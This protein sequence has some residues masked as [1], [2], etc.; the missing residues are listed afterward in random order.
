M[1]KEDKK[2]IILNKVGSTNN[3]ASRL[4]LSDAAEEGTVVLTHFQT[5][6]RGQAGNYWESETGKNL[7]A[8]LILYPGFLN[9]AKQFAISKIVSLGLVDFLEREIE[10]VSI[11]WP[12][13]IYVENRKIAGILIENTV[14]GN[15]LAS[16]VVGIGLNLNQEKF[17]SDAPNP[18]SLKQI[19]GEIY[20]VEFVASE[21]LNAIFK[22]YEKLKLGSFSEIDTAYFSKLYGVGVWRKFIKN[23]KIFEAKIVGVG[24]FGQLWLEKCDGIIEEFMFKEVE[25]VV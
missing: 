9:A 20:D 16:L 21:I 1:T 18:V 4:I 7:L 15:L 3:Y 23:D 22:W 8:S 25:F 13:D 19:T 2:I 14:K 10:S 24:E 12:N 17:L 5:S 11:K 6:G